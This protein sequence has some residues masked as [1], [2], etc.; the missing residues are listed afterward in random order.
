MVSFCLPLF[1]AKRTML[2]FVK[3]K[4]NRFKT[5]NVSDNK[6]NEVMGFK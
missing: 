5:K 6:E 4:E 2:E 1:S 3:I